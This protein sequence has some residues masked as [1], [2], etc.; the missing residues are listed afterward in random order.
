MDVNETLRLIAIRAPSIS[1]EAARA[2]RVSSPNPHVLSAIAM[3]A[4]RDPE[5]GWTTAERAAL[6]A[7]IEP[8]DNEARTERLNIR[9]SEAELAQAQARADAE[10]NGNLSAL[11]RRLLLGD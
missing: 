11:I 8:V 6:V 3:H 2:L 1:G 4:L 7:L 5:A 9:L 10:T